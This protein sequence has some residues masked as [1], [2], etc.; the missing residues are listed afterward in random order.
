[1]R[2]TIAVLG[3][4]LALAV[5]PVADAAAADRSGTV[6]DAVPFE[7]DGP[8]AIG[9]N[10]SYDGTTGEPCPPDNTPPRTPANQCDVT[11]LQVNAA[12]FG[13]VQ[14]SIAEN[15]DI[16]AAA[17]DFDLYVYASDSGGTRGALVA[18]SASPA[19][20]ES[21]FI[22]AGSG[23]YLIQVVYFD[24]TN[25]SYHGSAV[26][27]RR[28]QFPPDI[29]SPAGL[30]D[31]LASDPANG[32]RSHSEPHIAQS[33][34]NPN[35]LVAASKMYNR[36]QDSLQE[37]EFKIGTYVS[38]DGG[39]SWTD[40]GQLDVCPPASATPPS[41]PNNTC[42]P[43][44]N[45]ALGG[46]GAEDVG[47]PRGTGD[48][49]EEYITS[50]VWVQFDDEGN[51]YAM[52]LDSPP[53]PG[54]AGWGMTLHKWAT[55][56]AADVT[57]NNTWSARI[58][59]NSYP[60]AASDPNFTTL[61]DKNTFAV[62]NAGPDGDGTTGIMVACW[63][64]DDA[65]G[66]P[67]QEIVCERSADGGATWPDDPEPISGPQLLEIGVHV[68]ADPRD[69]NTFYATWLHYL[70][71]ALG[72]GLPDEMSFT[73]STDGGQTWDPPRTVAT[74]E[75]IPN[76]FPG[77][78]FR[79]LS[80]PIMAAGPHS[81]LYIVYSA[82]RDAPQ[83]ND[84]DDKQ[85]DVMMVRSPD[86]GT[87]WFAPVKVNQDSTN[88][89]QVQPYVAVTSGGQ[90]NVSYF[91]RRLDARR[92]EGATVVHPGNF[93]ID[94]WLSRSSDGGK[95]FSDARVSHDSWDPTI[96][97]PISGSG[98]FI[99]D[100]QGL[101]AD[102]SMAI[103]FVNDTH[104]A[105]DASRDPTFDVGEPRSVFQEVFS[106][107]VPNT[108]AYGGGACV[109]SGPPGPGP[110]E[111]EQPTTKL[112][113]RLRILS[114]RVHIT[115][116]GVAPLRVRCASRSICR[117]RLDVF[118]F[119]G[120]GGR[121][122]ARITVGA[123]RFVLRGGRNG[124]VRVRVHRKERKL[125]ERRGRICTVAVGRARFQSGGR[126]RAMK[127]VTLLPAR[128]EVASARRSRAATFCAA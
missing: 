49:G 89:D 23:Y 12:F 109:G 29:D 90:L 114:R 2:R 46:T 64:R 103:P 63:T 91:D 34:T 54:G 77:Q 36:D 35:L 120:R 56:S 62:N 28:D 104:L 81:E 32:F 52:V 22:D 25:D 61:D 51:A 33:P 11:L 124:T 16:P 50:D 6:T 39:Q 128:R 83:P 84:E 78:A 47:D 126:G 111:G 44:E 15:D 76:T 43:D 37:Y 53:F 117:G 122:P 94:T 113:S 3:S 119:I 100:Y 18:S 9:T 75:S 70:P 123:R 68:V 95:T 82:Y 88:A 38:F 118:R 14:V 17:D 40:L 8:A 4:L 45:P 93:F 27:S 99:G 31:V 106:S 41:W 58:P 107:R 13:G 125:A 92:T 74:L 73:T 80:I 79:N 48:F 21:T 97:P 7:W 30:P 24:V 116:R 127:K 59:I 105:N 57:A 101:V 115:P 72:L 96:N 110:K 85:A 5:L 121:P 67:P 71:G 102:C 1:M 98:Q 10:Q 86:G 65:P 60:D 26:F 112:Q 87:S 66:R 108:A 55:P 20:T 19:G 69:P 42:Y